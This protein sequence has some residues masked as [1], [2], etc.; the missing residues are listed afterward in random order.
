V[1]GLVP[2]GLVYGAPT[3]LRWLL[4]SFMLATFFVNAAG[5]FCLSA[6]LERKR[7]GAKQNAELTSVTMPTGLIEGTET[8]LFFILFI[9]LPQYVEVWFSLFSAGVTFSIFQRLYFASK[10]LN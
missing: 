1:Y 4:C 8:V 9:A 5:L 7:L 10:V 2:I 6:L 3:P